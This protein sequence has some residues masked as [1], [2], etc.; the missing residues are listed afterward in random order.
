MKKFILA[1]VLF[2]AFCCAAHAQGVI[3]E[4]VEPKVADLMKRFTDTNKSSMTVKGWRIQI[5]A[6]TD[7]DKMEIALRQFESL[8][9]NV[10]V[11]WIHSK[12]YYKMRAGAFMTK[13]DAL[14]TLAILKPDYPSAYPVQDNEIKPVELLGK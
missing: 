2:L 10:P 6:T 11:D 3:N 8:Y 5:L 12:P 7:R 13:R 14:Q 1:S 4:K 9:P